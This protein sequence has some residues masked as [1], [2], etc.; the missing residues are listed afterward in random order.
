MAKKT[1]FGFFFLRGRKQQRSMPKAKWAA[2][3]VKSAFGS[4]SGA[5][6][7]EG[8]TENVH[9]RKRPSSSHICFEQ[10]SNYLKASSSS[11]SQRPPTRQRRHICAKTDKGS[12]FCQRRFTRPFAMYQPKTAITDLH[13]SRIQVHKKS[14][15]KI[16]RNSFVFSRR[17][18]FPRIR[19]S[20]LKFPPLNPIWP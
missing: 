5:R 17:I 2:K 9:M 18:D 13:T 3:K 7:T 8:K 16:R 20:Q 1:L 6:N 14:F 10:A 4:L 11:P 15:K 12:S 19:C